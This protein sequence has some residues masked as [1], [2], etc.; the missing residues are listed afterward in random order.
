MNSGLSFKSILLKIHTGW[1]RDV[2]VIHQ[3]EV[4]ECGL[5]CIAMICS[6]YGKNTDM[7]SLRRRFC[8]PSRGTSLSGLKDIAGHMELSN[9]ALS[10]ELE[11]LPNLRLPCILHWDFSHYVVLTRVRRNG[12]VLHDPA[13]GRRVV[14]RDEMSRHFSG[15]VLEVWP[16]NEYKKDEPSTRLRIGSL[17]RNVYGL[18]P[19]LAKI[20][21]LS[22]AVETITLALPAGTALIMDHAVPASDHGLLSLVCIGL[23]FFIL[24]RAAFSSLRA[25]I[26]LITGTLI[27]IQ[28]QSGLFKHLLGLPLRY[29]ERRKFGDIQ[30]RFSSLNV[31]RETFTTSIVGATIDGLMMVG[32]LTVLILFGGWLTLPVLAFTMIDIL[33]RFATY[34]RY[35]QLSEESIIRQA[36]T[37]SFFMETLYGIGTVRMQGLGKRRSEDWINLEA[38]AI[39]TGLRVARMDMLFGGIN[40]LI[41][42]LEQVT[43]LWL[44]AGLVMDNHMTIGMFVAFSAYR[45]MFSTRASSLTGFVISLSMMSLHSERV[46]DIALEP[47][48]INLPERDI[49]L[50][51]KTSGISLKAIELSY[52]YDDLSPAVFINLNLNISAGESVA[53]AGSSGSGKSTLIKVLCGLAEPS[54]GTVL[55]DG[56]DI[57]KFG[58]NNFRKMIG[59]VMQDDRLFSGT[60]RENICA[61]SE[62]MDEE[63]MFRCA[64]T[65]SVHHVIMSMPMGYD[66]LV[67]ELGEGMSGGQKQRIYIARALYRRPLILFMDEATSALDEEH[68]LAVSEAIKRLNITRI[69]I[70]H[71][72]ST[73]AT[74]DRVI[75][76]S[77]H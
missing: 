31:L 60:L 47:Q 71:R 8:L 3:T 12:Y 56:I 49:H 17:L 9:R 19:A 10:L 72:A 64:E 15:V 39:N 57:R 37:Q 32:L 70:A 74:V 22:L 41:S 11:E 6:F 29:F 48:E 50:S 7:I 53:I 69:I 14:S 54:E 63:W 68:E 21:F 66:T 30:S 62:E 4:S 43:I 27:N 5:A 45:E 61:F 73:I 36:R 26:T 46:A 16:G 42:A 18:P 25:W 67:G 59:C 28:W 2:P 75:H 52:R 51:S 55:A 23:F 38:D 35:R 58:V 24:L 77:K 44:G 40:T 76:I 20:F 13:R 1:I 65:A 33:I 34:R